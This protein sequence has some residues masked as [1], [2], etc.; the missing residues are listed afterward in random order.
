MKARIAEAFLRAWYGRV[1]WFY[2]VLPLLWPLSLL[3]TALAAVRRRQLQKTQSTLPVPVVVVGNISVGGT[4]K[5][6]L[7]CA[8][9]DV[10]R[11]QG[12]TPGI[13][14]RGYGGMHNGAPRRVAVT[15]VATE[16]GDEP[17]L[18][19]RRTACPVVIGC[20][21]LA[22]AEM[23]LQQAHCDVILS[24]DGLQHYAL[25]RDVEIVV[26]D[27]VRGIGNGHCLPAGP[28]REPPARLQEV[29]LVVVNGDAGPCWR[30]DQTRMQVRPLHWLHMGS[31]ECRALDTLPQGTRVHALAGI[32]NPQRFFASLRSL[33]LDVVEH[34][35]PDHHDYQPGDLV[36]SE[37]LP[38]VMTEKDAVKCS[39]LL[40]PT[41]G[42]NAWVLI[43][44]AQLENDFAERLLQKI[45][46]AQAR[47]ASKKTA[48]E[49][50]KPERR[51]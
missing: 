33:G 51:T 13:I 5:T 49:R 47:R 30:A 2:L 44:A 19:V 32:G 10:L 18:L 31:G 4:G 43:V 45:R 25:P 3:F 38:L 37:Y 41:A 14:A 12:M 29:D 34:V 17:L 46:S 15:D 24:D 1:W 50:R 22:A 39:D 7:L 40:S 26:I 42:E 36:F 35:F 28:L 27:A 48:Q 8:I 9:V 6:P 23:L 21:R 16:V 11:A 20:S